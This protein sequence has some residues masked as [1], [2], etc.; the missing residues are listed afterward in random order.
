[1]LLLSRSDDFF[2]LQAFE[3][4]RR[5]LLTGLLVFLEADTPGQVAISCIFAIF[6]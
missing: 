6:R 3:C 5:L 2:T 1:M 4:I